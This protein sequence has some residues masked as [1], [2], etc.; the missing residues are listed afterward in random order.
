MRPHIGLNQSQTVITV[1][2][3]FFNRFAEQLSFSNSLSHKA[4]AR[5]I[6]LHDDSVVRERDSFEERIQLVVGLDDCVMKT[7]R[8]IN[9]RLSNDDPAPIIN[10]DERLNACHEERNDWVR[11]KA[12]LAGKAK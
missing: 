1:V 8:L 3:R 7:R 11:S 5:V 9:H 6:R 10:E 2:R 4:A 12:A